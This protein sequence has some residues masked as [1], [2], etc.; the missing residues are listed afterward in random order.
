MIAMI[1]AMEAALKSGGWH[2]E[3]YE[4]GE[5]S[6]SVPA[7]RPAARILYGGASFSEPL[8]TSGDHISNVLFVVQLFIQPG[9]NKSPLRHVYQKLSEARGACNGIS[10]CGPIDLYCSREYYLGR[11]AGVYCYVQ[12]YT[13]KG[14]EE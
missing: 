3:A 6:D 2:V 13:A 12:E 8:Y 5:R 11:N 9:K 10:S 1:D 4:D 14:Y 7:V